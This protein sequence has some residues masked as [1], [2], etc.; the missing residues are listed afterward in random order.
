MVGIGI[1]GTNDFFG[2]GVFTVVAPLV[3]IGE[4]AGSGVDTTGALGVIDAGFN[5]A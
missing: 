4:A 5:S 1:V 2:A 3:S